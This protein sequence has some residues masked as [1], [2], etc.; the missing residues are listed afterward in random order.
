MAVMT[1][2]KSYR[3]GIDVGGT[4]IAAVL[5]DPNN[6]VIEHVVLATPRES[7][8]HFLIM[9]QAAV[10]PLLARIANHKGELAGIG[11][12]VPGSVNST[13]EQII[14]AANLPILNGVRLLILLKQ[15]LKRPDIVCALDN[16]AKCFVRAEAMLGAGKNSQNFYGI[17]I[18]TGIGGAWWHNGEIHHGFHHSA[19]GPG[20]MIID[21]DQM[22]SLE[23]AYHSLTQ[24][25]PALMADEAY[26]G[27]R[28]AE[29]RFEEVGAYLGVAFST[30]V[31][32]IDP[33]MIVLG[34]GALAASDLFLI[35]T[36]ES[37][38]KNVSP[39]QAK[40]IK[41]VKGRVGPLAGAIGAALLIK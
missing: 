11:V 14:S 25:N 35:A 9:M 3:I 36:K 32:L 38:R 34:G 17:T 6:K 2:S 20:H 19:G 21:V 18:G 33:E 31:K 39:Y 1:T 37:M 16:D 24:N 8:K 12:G 26:R 23:Q 28:I 40:S 4:K 27:D 22:I 29:Q 5:I 10:D 41:L 15:Q 30:I 7:L 13:K